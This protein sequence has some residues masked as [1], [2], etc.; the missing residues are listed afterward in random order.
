MQ[1]LVLAVLSSAP[2]PDQLTHLLSA[3]VSLNNDDIGPEG[4]PSTTLRPCSGHGTCGSDGRC[5]CDRGYSA[6]ACERREYLFS[7]PANCS[8]PSGGACVRDRCVCAPGRSGDDCASLT[9]VNC[10]RDCSGHGECIADRRTGLTS[11]ECAAGYYG[12]TCLL[13]CDGYVPETGAPC[14]GRGLCL[15]TGSPGHS[16]ERC[17]CHTGFEGAGCELDVEG[18]TTCPREC[19]GHGVCSGGRCAC[20]EHYAGHDCSIELRHGRLAHALD[21]ASARVVAAFGCFVLTAGCAALAI[22]YINAEPKERPHAE[23]LQVLAPRG[24]KKGGA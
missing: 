17:K 23:P 14:S 16:A 11:C 12:P 24:S 7:C 19:S 4:C 22:R 3:P 18:V 21:S 15:P 8:W 5:R 10:T 1:L 20:D 9:P 6:L 2:R 13:G